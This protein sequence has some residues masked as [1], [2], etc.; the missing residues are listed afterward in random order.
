MI[1]YISIFCF[2]FESIEQTR[3]IEIEEYGISIM[4]SPWETCNKDISIHPITTSP[5]D[6]VLQSDEVV[7]AV[8]LKFSPP[9]MRFNAPVKITLPHCAVLT[10]PER[11]TPRF[12][13]RFSGNGMYSIRQKINELKQEQ[14]GR[15]FIQ[16]FLLEG[17]G[18]GG[19]NIICPHAHY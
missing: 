5:S 4:I 9:G 12:Y 10:N 1:H 6:L 18:G 14:L 2:V 7:I 16:D 17:G 19:Q 11:F 13:A 15:L 8:G 3:T